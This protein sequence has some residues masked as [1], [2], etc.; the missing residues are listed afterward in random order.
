MSV[1]SDKKKKT[2]FGI[3]VVVSVIILITVG[4]TFAYFTASINSSENAV[5]IKS[6]VFKL[7]LDDDTDLIKSN[8]IPTEERFVDMV[9]DRRDDSGNFIKPYMDGDALVKENTVC[10]DDNLNEICSLYTFTVINP[11]TDLDVPLYITLD[12]AYNS[13]ENLFYKVVD[14]ELNEVISATPL[15]DNRYE[16]IGEGINRKYNKDADNNLIK[17][18]NFDSL[19]LPREILT[20]INLVLPKSASLK[21][22]DLSTVTYSIVFWINENYERQNESDGGKIFMSTLTVSA[23]GADGMGITGVFSSA[24]TE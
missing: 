3:L 22:E 12:V 17:L 18:D 13:F 19:P 2:I 15:L 21:D 4:S 20:N 10:I 1:M 8:L 9:I 24:G 5:D 6:A 11:M 7:E 23:S 16:I 14:S